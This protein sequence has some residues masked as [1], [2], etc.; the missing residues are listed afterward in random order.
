MITTLLSALDSDLHGFKEQILSSETLTSA[1]NV[2][3]HYCAHA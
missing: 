2:N 1:A 3:S